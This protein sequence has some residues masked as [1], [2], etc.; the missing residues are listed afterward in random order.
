M[1][2]KSMNIMMALTATANLKTTDNILRNLEMNNHYIVSEVPN[3]PSIFLA[4]LLSLMRS[5]KLLIPPQMKL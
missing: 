4:V 2:H 3:N 1:F 5:G